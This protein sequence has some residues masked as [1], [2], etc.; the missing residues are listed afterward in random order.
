MKG[1]PW[2]IDFHGLHVE[3][4]IEFLKERIDTLKKLKKAGE[5]MVITG[6]GIHSDVN[7]P[8]IKP[9]VATLLKEQK[10]TFTEHSSDGS[11]IV[12]FKV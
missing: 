11:F 10:L 3:P 5:L 2:T 8:K 6:A 1:D 9:A 4:A 12:T 7:G